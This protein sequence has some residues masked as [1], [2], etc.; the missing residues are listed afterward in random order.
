MSLEVARGER[1]I[2]Q[3]ADL[4]SVGAIMY[5]ALC[6][7]APFQ[8]EG[9]GQVLSRIFDHQIDPLVQERPELPAP[10]VAFVEKALAHEAKDRHGSAE[11]M[12]AAMKQLEA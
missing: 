10:L 12:A 7:H 1:D 2:D 5:H 3:R 4:F 8:G 11:E 9:F 6:G